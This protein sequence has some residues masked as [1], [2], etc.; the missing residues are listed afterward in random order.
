MIFRLIRADEFPVGTGAILLR[1]TNASQF[2]LR[3]EGLAR[4]DRAI[5]ALDIASSEAWPMFWLEFERAPDEIS[6]DLA[7]SDGGGVRRRI[8]RDA[9]GLDRPR[10]T[11]GPIHLDDSGLAGPVLRSMLDWTSGS[12]QAVLTL[13]GRIAKDRGF[14]GRGRDKYFDVIAKSLLGDPSEDLAHALRQALNDFTFICTWRMAELAPCVLT[15]SP[16]ELAREFQECAAS[17]GAGFRWQ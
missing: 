12:E 3:T 10:R 11:L 15:L 7:A 13:H 9:W 1:R 5:D 14:S 16:L 2:S 17:E 8:F 4:E 6:L